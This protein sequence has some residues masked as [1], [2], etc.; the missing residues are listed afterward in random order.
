MPTVT[1]L[2]AVTTDTVGS[3]QAMDGPC[4]VQVQGDGGG[5]ETVIEASIDDV[6]DNYQHIGAVGTV[7]G[8]KGGL[9]HCHFMGGYYIRARHRGCTG[10]A[11]RTVRASN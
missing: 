3:G 10:T 5:G 11:A 2:N 6:A 7:R 9:V 1:L 8:N 4:T